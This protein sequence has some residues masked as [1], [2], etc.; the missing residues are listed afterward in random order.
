MTY[1]FD[2]RWLILMG[3]G[4]PCGVC[5]EVASVGSPYIAAMGTIVTWQLGCG[6]VEWVVPTSPLCPRL[7][8]RTDFPSRDNRDNTPR[9]SNGC[10]N[11]Q[12]PPPISSPP[13]RNQ[14]AWRRPSVPFGPS[15]AT[16]TIA[17]KRGQHGYLLTYSQQPWRTVTAESELDRNMTA[18]WTASSA[19]IGPHS[20]H[21]V[22][23][24]SQH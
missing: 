20:N 13:P 8:A 23:P 19:D 22:V 6:V 15:V 10:G 2:A 14:S 5:G 3:C 24:P 4:P 7:I 21:R 9:I 18:T 16:T 12:P 11:T 17:E 1:L